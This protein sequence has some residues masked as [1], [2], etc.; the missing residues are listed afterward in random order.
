M[1][2]EYAKFALKTFKERKLRSWLTMLGIFIGIAAVVSLIS[3]GQGL[4]LAI[5]QQFEEMGT[6]KII[7]MP[8]SGLAGLIGVSEETAE[9]TDKDIDVVKRVKGIK[10]VS[11]W[12][13]KLAKVEYNKKIIYTW[14]M[15]IP[16][17]SESKRLIESMQNIETNLGRDLKSGDRY[18]AQ[19]GYLLANEEA[20]FGKR[21]GIASTIKIES[22]DFKVVGSL[23]RIGNPDDDSSI[24]IPMKV[25]MEI[26]DMPDEYSM[27]L[28]QVQQ[29]SSPAKAADSIKRELRKS[30]NLEEGDEDFSVQT[31]EELMRT[32]SA[33]FLIVQIVI[34][35]IAA[36]SL[37]VGGIGI[38]NTM[39]T[40]LSLKEP[41]KSG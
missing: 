10:Y 40:P 6:D 16:L 17:D 23:K 5:S 3:L 41:K 1:I 9:L 36:I 18:K 27:V 2:E 14:V 13:Y 4:Q 24:I 39:Y 38:M 32:Y 29:G 35:G 34:I 19:I 33:I 15:G 28:A 31:A 7:I 8:G 22:K 20:K 11:G 25:A 21:V 37:I 26:L 12:V 30:R